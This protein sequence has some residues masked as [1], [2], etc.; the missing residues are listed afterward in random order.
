VSRIFSGKLVEKIVKHD[1]WPIWPDILNPSF[2]W[3]TSRKLLWLDL[4][5]V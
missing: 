3:L 4:Q 1:S 5:P 2:L